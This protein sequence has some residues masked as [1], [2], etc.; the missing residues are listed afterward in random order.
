M[1]KTSKQRID[2]PAIPTAELPAGSAPEAAMLPLDVPRTITLKGAQKTLSYHF[3]RITAA[4]WQAFF[5]AIVHQTLQRGPVRETVYESETAQIELVEKALKSVDGYGDLSSLKNWK[6]AL[7]LTHRLSVGVVLRNV[8]ESSR[9]RETAQLADLITI[10][11]DAF[12]SAG[13]KGKA[14]LYSGLVHRFRQPSIAQLRHFNFET[15]RVRVEGTAENGITTYP[16]RQLVAMRIYDELIEEVDGYSVD[17][18]PL[19]GIENIQREMDGAH[20][21]EAALALFSQG[22]AVRVQ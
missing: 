4:D 10:E 5:A 18:K 16:A 13:D 17:G 6:A 19:V 7:P 21:A 12:W 20:K 14:T 22:D 9:P 8:G 15:A 3:R 11:L 2:A 1:A